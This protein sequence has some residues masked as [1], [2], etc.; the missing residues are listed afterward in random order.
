MMTPRRYLAIGLVIATGS[1]LSAT[2]A[3]F[4][5]EL[6]ETRAEAMS[7]SRSRIAFSLCVW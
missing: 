1:A 7:R 4:V 3:G 6:E 5:N 2:G